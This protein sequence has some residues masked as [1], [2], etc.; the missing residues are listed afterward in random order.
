MQ[1]PTQGLKSQTVRS[2]LELK[3]G[4]GRFT[5][6]ATQAPPKRNVFKV[7]MHVHQ[8]TDASWKNLSFS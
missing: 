1:S 3:S 5:D 6:G 8:Q 2:R 7:T 4:V